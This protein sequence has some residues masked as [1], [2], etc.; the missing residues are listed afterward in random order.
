[1]KL[2]AVTLA[3]S[4]VAMLITV[5]MADCV[6]FV[7]SLLDGSSTPIQVSDSSFAYEGRKFAVTKMCA[8]WDL[9]AYILAVVACVISLRKPRCHTIIRGFV[10]LLSGLVVVQVLN[11]L[12]IATAVHLASHG[13]NWEYVHDAPD[14]ALRTI[15]YITFGILIL[16]VLFTGSSGSDLDEKMAIEI[17]DN[18]ARMQP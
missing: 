3:L 9:W 7:L 16:R 14:I 13:M 4:V 12:R 15:L 5:E 1:M 2:V 17:R 11:V 6:S 10:F 18:S 8:Y